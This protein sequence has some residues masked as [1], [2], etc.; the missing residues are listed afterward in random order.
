MEV[1]EEEEETIGGEN[2]APGGGGGGEQENERKGK[3]ERM[4]RVEGRITIE[5]SNREK[6]GGKT[7]VTEIT[8]IGRERQTEKEEGTKLVEVETRAIKKGAKEIT[9]VTKERIGGGGGGGV[10]VCRYAPWWWCLPL[11][12]IMDFWQHFFGL[13]HDNNNTT[14]VAV[15]S[16]QTGQYIR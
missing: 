11:V 12:A 8:T 5:D 2:L 7:R 16:A 4:I 9:V 14:T 13:N 6:Q 3:A 10:S 15:H 1:K